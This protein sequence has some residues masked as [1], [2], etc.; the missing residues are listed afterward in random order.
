MR[1]DAPTMRQINAAKDELTRKIRKSVVAL[2]E[3]DR[4][5]YEARECWKAKH[6]T[7]WD[8]VAKKVGGQRDA[9]QCRADVLLFEARSGMMSGYD[10]V[11]RVTEFEERHE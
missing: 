4:W 8:R 9:M 7:P 3:A 11:K 5:T 6:P 2:E 1:K 10:L